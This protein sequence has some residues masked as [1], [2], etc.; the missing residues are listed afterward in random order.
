MSWLD[1]Y[2]KDLGALERV[3]EQAVP[4]DPSKPAEV[5]AFAKQLEM[6]LAPLKGKKIDSKM[7]DLVAER[8]WNEWKDTLT[9]SLKKEIRIQLRLMPLYERLKNTS[10]AGLDEFGL[11]ILRCRLR[12]RAFRELIRNLEEGRNYNANID[13]TPTKSSTV[14]S[15]SR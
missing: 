1:R 5:A 6:L 12:S 4:V 14:S 7:L 13:S 11:T 10:K 9:T 3:R 2:K 15:G 8:L